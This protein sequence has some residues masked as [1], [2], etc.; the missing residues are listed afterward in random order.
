MWTQ[1]IAC[2]SV[3]WMLV[4]GQ[5]SQI[6]ASA[7]A[8]NPHSQRPF[9]FL[10]DFSHRWGKRRSPDLLFLHIWSVTG[11]QSFMDRW[12]NTIYFC[13][14]RRAALPGTPSAGDQRGLRQWV[15][16]IIIEAALQGL[17]PMGTSTSLAAAFGGGEGESKVIPWRRQQKM[18]LTQVFPPK[19][20]APGFSCLPSLSFHPSPCL[21]PS[22]I[23]GS[24]Q[25]N[26]VF[27]PGRQF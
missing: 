13:E 26:S 5:A 14:L 8:C 23:Y 6:H 10:S 11:K 4:S 21:P 19:I 22:R 9:L 17:R 18:V 25:C 24:F 2:P 12:Y 1:I 16:R 27:L 3:A 7:M 15:I 20:W